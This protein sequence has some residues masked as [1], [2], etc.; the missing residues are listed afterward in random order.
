M[1]NRVVCWVYI[2][3][4]I[5]HNRLT[6][7]DQIYMAPTTRSSLLYRNIPIFVAFMVTLLF[8]LG[9][10]SN[11]Q[12]ENISLLQKRIEKVQSQLGQI[13][14]IEERLK[15]EKDILQ[16]E[17]DKII[18]QNNFYNGL[19]VAI[20]QS[21]GCS[22]LGTTAYVGYR[23]FKVSEDNLKIAQ[24]KHLT[25]RFSKAIEHLG[26]DKIDVRLG[27]IYTLEQLAINSQKYHWTIVEILSA[28]IR[29]KSP[30]YQGFYQGE[31]NEDETGMSLVSEISPVNYGE[32]QTKKTPADDGD[33][34]K[35]QIFAYEEPKI[36]KP[37]VDI[38]AAMVVLSR[39]TTEHE[40]EQRRRIDLRT[41]NLA[42][43]EIE[44][45]NLNN[46]NLGNAYLYMAYLENANLSEAHLHRTYLKNTNL[47]RA[48]LRGANLRKANLSEARLEE[49]NMSESNLRRANLSAAH[50]HSTNL[51]SANLSAADLR[52]A[53]LRNANLVG[54]DLKNADLRNANLVGA[55]LKN[56]DLR[57]ANLVGADL[58]NA[59]LGNANLVG[60]DLRNANLVGVDLKQVNLA[61][62]QTD[63]GISGD[64]SGE[65]STLIR[66]KNGVN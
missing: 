64:P 9:Y 66:F 19:F 30:R 63:Q 1:C 53:D 14:S 43:I 5:G 52:N 33:Q 12:Q 21:I 16:V 8:V 32:N 48:N 17:K 15:L 45:A 44:G 46:I 39:R 59:D 3:R 56:A 11:I 7:E 22:V 18:I 41:V 4:T 10:L 47:R 2:D 35:S 58:K 60:A 50:L 57:N 40:V 38:I 37:T 36:K 29:E 27:G 61:G 49:A 31:N 25:D 51:S 6:I 62:A 13:R 23:N 24:D 42:E 54:A 26:S 65:I 55:D 20:F 34:P 28:F